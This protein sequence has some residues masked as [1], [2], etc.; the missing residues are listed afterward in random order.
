MV[1]HQNDSESIYHSEWG[2]SRDKTRLKVFENW[3]F[4]NEFIFPPNL[5][6]TRTIGSELGQ[7][8]IVLS[9]CELRISVMCLLVNQIKAK[10][11]YYLSIT[12]VIYKD[13]VNEKK[14]LANCKCQSICWLT[15]IKTKT[16]NKQTIK[17]QKIYLYVLNRSSR[18]F[19]NI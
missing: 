16:K 2:L 5:C 11:F 13:Y 9:L 14:S 12:C 18:F 8:N 19:L 15:V 3:N 4:W 1:I 7:D 10:K 6:C 17:K